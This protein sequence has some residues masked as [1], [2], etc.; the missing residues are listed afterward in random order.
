MQAFLDNT[1]SEFQKLRK[2]AESA[3][4]QVSDDEFFRALDAESNNLAVLCQHLGGNMMSRWSGF[5]TEDG[6]KPDRRRDAEFEVAS[7]ATRDQ[8]MERW[9]AGWQCLFDNLGAL[10]PEARST[11]THTAE[12]SAE[13]KADQETYSTAALTDI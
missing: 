11:E 12:G 13:G 9:Q 7:S 4:S 3:L 6:E 2:Q 10:T 1:M 5:L 8:I